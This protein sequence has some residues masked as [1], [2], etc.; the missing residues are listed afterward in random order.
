MFQWERIQTRKPSARFWWMW[1]TWS[2]SNETTSSVDRRSPT[3]I[4]KPVQL[5]N[6]NVS[7]G[8]GY[9]LAFQIIPGWCIQ[10]TESSRFCLLASC[11]PPFSSPANPTMRSYILDALDLSS[12]PDPGTISFLESQST[13]TSPF[14]NLRFRWSN[15]GESSSSALNCHEIQN[16]VLH[17]S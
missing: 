15:C 7:K 6:V 16:F 5:F 10:D 4:P 9:W 14:R 12:T 11:L 1:L 17:W 13:S 3:A 2:A 8:S